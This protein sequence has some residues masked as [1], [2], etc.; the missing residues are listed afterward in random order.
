MLDVRRLRVLVAVAEHGSLTAAATAL[1]YTQ[2]AIS[3]QI[4]VLEAEAGVQLLQRLPQGVAVTDAGALL[5]ARAREI[6]A[7]LSRTESELDALR[8]LDSGTLAITA[9]ASGAASVIPPALARFRERHPAVELTVTVADPVD[10]L[11]QLSAGE[12]DI[13]LC[14]QSEASAGGRPGL[15]GPGLPVSFVHLFN[16]PMFVALP[17]EHPLTEAP[18]L[19][20]GDL[21][22]EPWMLTT[23]ATCPDSELFLSACTR[24]GVVPRVAFQYDDY[25]ALLGFVTAGV[26]IA[27]V[28]EMVARSARADVTLRQLDPPLPARPVTAAVNAAYRSAPVTA[29]LEILI[30]L[31]PDWVAGQI[32]PPSGAT[33]A[34]APSHAVARAGAA[35]EAG[36]L[37][38]HLRQQR[39]G[40]LEGLAVPEAGGEQRLEPGEQG[41]PA[42]DVDA[43]T[44]VLEPVDERV[45]AGLQRDRLAQ[46][47]GKTGEHLVEGAEVGLCVLDE[48]G[49][50]PRH[51]RGADVDAAE[52]DLE[53]QRVGE[54]LDAG[55]GG[56]VGD[57]PGCGGER[58][59]G[60][61]DQHV[62]APLKDGGEGRPHR[63]EDAEHVDVEHPPED[64]RVD[65]EHRAVAGDTRVGEDEVDPAEALDR[66]RRGGLHRP[67]V[68][69][70]AGD[71]E[72]VLGPELGGERGERRLIDVGED[73]PG[74]PLNRRP[75]G[76]RADPA[77][78]AGD[79]EDLPC[80]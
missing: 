59:L 25:A 34:T 54:V 4:A 5:V 10:S 2:P 51:V 50:D 19:A 6:L 53:A 79:E 49:V 65:G 9:F 41:D 52:G 43:A 68:A 78:G 14:N 38:V 47:A 31:A 44:A 48:R 76:A 22:A 69:D 3:R 66:R 56:V 37:S 42:G 24:A 15:G 63:V 46:R 21:A 20:L 28:P 26:G 1:G 40:L 75:G 12:L 80:E 29:M 11:P 58:S 60:G 35:A 70:I 39:L 32:T 57:E 33:R 23:T 16:D 17:P 45:D 74:A 7:T 62:A 13:A 71:R 61:D 8:G 55:L 72:G 30:E 67:E 64:G 27:V 36:D 73:D 18:R 77:G